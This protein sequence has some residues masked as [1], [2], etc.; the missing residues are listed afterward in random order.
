V[1]GA[2]IIL[3]VSSVHDRGRLTGLYNTWFFLGAAVGALA[4]GFL[5]DRLG[6]AAAMWIGAGLTAVGGVVAYGLLP[7]TRGLRP[8]PEEI[9]REA[10][11][12]DP[13]RAPARGLWLAAAMQGVN[14][15][16][17]AGVLMATLGLLVQDRLGQA[18]ELFGVA[19][20]TGLLM[21]GRTSLSIV[22]APAAGTA[23]DRFGS[24]WRVAG[25]MLVAGAAGMALLAQPGPAAILAGLGLAAV[26]GGGIQVLAT[27]LTG[28]LAS[29]AQR[30]RALGW[31]NTAGDL[32]SALGPPVAYALLPWLG[33]PVVYWLC[34]ALFAL[35]WFLV[36][37][38][39][40]V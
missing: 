22:A 32:G 37:V 14:R 39:Q 8:P 38:W 36:L 27:T 5:T 11:E 19:T 26:A 40:R 6:Y 31:L 21:A 20:V 24:R 35:Q 33:L 29:A 3:D 34:A 23:S 15:F 25:W 7:E 1:G 17:T 4:G 12:P 28:D 30:G 13:V 18:G 2:V 10:D 9:V 16:I